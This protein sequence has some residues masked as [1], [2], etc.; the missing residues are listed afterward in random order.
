MISDIKNRFFTAIEQG[1]IPHAC[2]VACADMHESYAIA[3]KASALFCTGSADTSKLENC[4]DFFELNDESYSADSVR[5]LL[6]TLAKQPYSDKYGR[7]VIFKNAHTMNETSQNALLKTL[8]E[9]PV[10]TLFL[11]TGNEAGLLP[12]IRSR[13]TMIRLG[14]PPCEETQAMLIR[15]GA[16]EKEA[17]LYTALGEGLFER[18][19]KLFCDERFRELR[20]ASIEAL[21][22]FLEGKLAFDSL[23]ILSQ[24]K[25]ASEAITFM[26]SFMRDM[27]LYKINARVEC[28][29]DKLSCIASLCERF[30]IGKIN[31]IIDII[32]DSKSRLT[33]SAVHA[34]IIDRMFTKIS[35]EI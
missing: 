25:S 10:Q 30:T 18:A 34:P 7:S 23:K 6:K 13:C 27:L 21:I 11:L 8:E 31:S 4:P 14:T 20:E 22:S 26:L 17:I 16:L 1:R 12:T 32:T 28:N 3:R 33:V 29:V 15:E 19:Y 5:E 2:F 35:E 9:P 24:N